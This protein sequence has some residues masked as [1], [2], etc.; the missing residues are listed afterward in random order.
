MTNEIKYQGVSLNLSDYEAVDGELDIAFNVIP[1]EGGLS[2]VLQP[3]RILQLPYTDTVVFVHETSK[4]KHYIIKRGLQL[5]WLGDENP[6]VENLYTLDNSTVIYKYTAIGNTLVILTNEGMQYFLFV[7]ESSTGNPEYISLGNH[8]PETAISFGL[9][10]RM[11][12]SQPFKFAISHESNEILA[13]GDKLTDDE[14]NEFT[15]HLLAQVNKFIADESTN[16]GRFIFPFF[17]RYAYRLYDNSLIMHS[18]P[19]L[20]LCTSDTPIAT[21]YLNVNNKQL[22]FE[23]V[24]SALSHQLDYQIRRDDVFDT[25]NLSKWSDIVKSIDIFISKPLYTYDQNGQ[26]K[27]IGD[28]ESDMRQIYSVCAIESKRTDYEAYH[29]LRYHYD[30]YKDT[31]FYQPGIAGIPFPSSYIYLG[32]TYPVLPKKDFAE[33]AKECSNYYFVKSIEIND[34]INDDGTRKVIE[35]D[36]DYL[37]SLVNREVMTDDYDSHDILIPR[38]A[39][40][41]N[42]RFN[43]ANIDKQLFK[44]FDAGSM[45]CFTDAFVSISYELQVA[46]DGTQYYKRVSNVNNQLTNVQCWVYLKQD[47]KDFCVRSDAFNFAFSTPF[48]WFYYPNPNAYKAVI[49]YLDIYYIIDLKRHDFLSGSYFYNNEIYLV[50]EVNAPSWVSDKPIISMHNKIYSSETNNPFI[51]PVVNICTVSTGEIIGLSSSAKALSEGQFGSF[52]VYAFTTDGVWALSVSGTG[53]FSAKQ[54]MSYDVCINPSSITQL[55]NSVLF[56]TDRGIMLIQGSQTQCITD[57]IFNVDEIVISDLPHIY[58]LIDVYNK[59][60]TFDEYIGKDPIKI[61]PFVDYIKNC[62]I[63]YDYVHQRIIVTNRIYPYSYVFS[64]LTKRW[65]M[66]IFNYFNKV[67]SYPEAYA[68]IWAEDNKNYLVD[69]CQKSDN[70]KATFIIVTRPFKLKSHDIYKTVDTIIQRGSFANPKQVSQILYGTRDY[71]TWHVIWSSRTKFMRGFSGTPYKAFKLAVAGT[72]KEV[73][74]LYGFTTNYNIKDT[75]KLR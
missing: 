49:K 36:E 34:I 12:R 11:V 44:G 20:M 60:A 13:V 55:D 38:V 66:L 72:L 62:S 42:A 2:P 58:L 28:A 16:K 31:F 56:A 23:G 35:I 9:T 71:A 5:L 19:V 59:S 1:N 7:E 50:D 70:D 64:F 24:I 14:S 75:N 61:K 37:Q 27:D 54:P 10:S 15:P 8:I 3:K 41:Y 46:D 43:I 68:M 33:E 21:G 4:F 65:G 52:P 73:E 47:G 63:I 32:A 22:E 26:V 17:V 51:F 40:P 18:A 39:Y 6:D 25:A 57:T 30:M 69:F 48:R 74:R 67:D 53:G 29:S 45:F